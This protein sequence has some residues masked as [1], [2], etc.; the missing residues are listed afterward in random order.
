MCHNVPT[1]RFL[2]HRSG[3]DAAIHL[4]HDLYS[5]VPTESEPDRPSTRGDGMRI[6]HSPRCAALARTTVALA[7]LTEGL[8]PPGRFCLV[9]DDYSDT[10]FIGQP[11]QLPHEL[12]SQTVRHVAANPAHAP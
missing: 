10:E 6:G 4:C 8:S 1:D 11:E 12:H 3:K 7:W 9:C 5:T 2:V